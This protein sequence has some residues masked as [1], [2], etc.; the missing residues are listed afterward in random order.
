MVV[1][2]AVGAEVEAELAPSN[3]LIEKGLGGGRHAPPAL[4]SAG[5][6]KSDFGR[7][8]FF[9]GGEGGED[10]VGGDVAEVEIRGEA[11]G[12]CFGGFIAGFEVA[13]KFAG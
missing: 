9:L 7:L 5:G 1:I 12:H 13:G 11:A 3:E 4:A 10:F 6:A 8:P 2:G